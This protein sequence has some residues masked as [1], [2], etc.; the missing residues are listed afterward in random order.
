MYDIKNVA[1][2][3]E[4]GSRSQN[5]FSFVARSAAEEYTEQ[6]PSPLTR[7]RIAI[8]ADLPFVH[9]ATLLSQTHTQKLYVHKF[10]SRL[11]YTRYH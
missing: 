11:T 6:T 1:V 2:M 4:E 7:L 10:Y 5:F 8:P 3:P 9:A